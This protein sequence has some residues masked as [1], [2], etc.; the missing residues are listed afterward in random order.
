MFRVLGIK[1]VQPTHVFRHSHASW[2][3][4]SGMNPKAVSQRI[5]HGNVAFTLS[6]YTHPDRAEDEK[7]RRRRWRRCCVPPRARRNK[8]GTS[9]ADAAAM[10]QN[11]QKR[12]PSPLKPAARPF[13]MWQ[14]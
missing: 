10:P 8:R 1:G 3:M 6:T 14:K 13:R 9:E 5:G 12:C 2:L 11:S 4:A 7:G